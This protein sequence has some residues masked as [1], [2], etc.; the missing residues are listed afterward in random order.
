MSKRPR[1][2]EEENLPKAK[3]PKQNMTLVPFPN[4]LMTQVRMFEPITLTLTVPQLMDYLARYRQQYRVFNV[5]VDSTDAYED[6]NEELEHTV[7]PVIGQWNIYFD[8]LDDSALSLLENLALVNNEAVKVIINNENTAA[9][10]SYADVFGENIGN[11]HEYARNGTLVIEQLK[12]SPN[13]TNYDELLNILTTIG[14]AVKRATMIPRG[15]L[16]NVLTVQNITYNPILVNI[17]Q[18]LTSVQR[19]DYAYTNENEAMTNEFCTFLLQSNIPLR[20]LSIDKMFMSERERNER[21]QYN[22]PLECIIGIAQTHPS[23]RNIELNDSNI[24]KITIAPENRTVYLQALNNI[25]YLKLKDSIIAKN[26]LALLLDS[27][28]RRLYL[29][30]DMYNDTWTREELEQEKGWSPTSISDLLMGNVKPLLYLDLVS[31]GYPMALIQHPRV[32]LITFTTDFNTV[33]K[34]YS[35]Y[36]HFTRFQSAL[37]GMVSGIVGKPVYRIL[38]SFFPNIKQRYEMTNSERSLEAWEYVTNANFNADKVDVLVTVEWKEN[39]YQPW[40]YN[41]NTLELGAC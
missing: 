15:G 13:V 6:E 27:N 23:L 4:E 30:S 2:E 20:H 29:T 24:D 38:I 41:E 12:I 25:Q 39:Q 9:L 37:L 35:E 16:I 32:R 31:N 28:I 18:R 11:V 17:L 21:I 33:P 3:R 14:P 1:S 22:F 10:A 5:I 40:C 34:D 8:H 36:Y 7:L 26:S 19:I